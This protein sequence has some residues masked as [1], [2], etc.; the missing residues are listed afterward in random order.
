[1]GCRL[2]NGDRK[3]KKRAKI[4]IETDLGGD[5][6]TEPFPLAGVRH[7]DKNAGGK[8]KKPGRV[9]SHKA[10]SKIKPQNS[11]EDKRKQDA[12]IP[13]TKRGYFKHLRERIRG[14]DNTPKRAEGGK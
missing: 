1:L 3:N 9:E 6:G 4:T 14:V 13:L 5:R 7:R 12:G 2:K 8:K 10:K 11:E